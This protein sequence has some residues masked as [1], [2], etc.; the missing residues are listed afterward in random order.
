MYV[1]DNR[2]FCYF[3]HPCLLNFYKD[4]LSLIFSKS[5][6]NLEIGLPMIALVDSQSTVQVQSYSNIQQKKKN[7]NKKELIDESET[8]DGKLTKMN[9]GGKNKQVRK[10]NM[11]KTSEET[12]W[13]PIS[14][15]K[16][17]MTI[18]N[19]EMIKRL[20]VSYFNVVKKNINDL[21][22]K[23]VVTMLIQHCRIQCEKILVSN[24]YPKSMYDLH[25]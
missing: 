5:D 11:E 23:T 4:I 12:A 14:Q 25:H 7:N 22:P 16:P 2:L 3:N 13:C 10:D 6:V 24:L 1:S 17:E 8:I 20:I 15:L 9:D 18:T 21:V 19:Q